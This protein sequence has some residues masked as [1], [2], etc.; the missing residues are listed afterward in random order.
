MYRVTRPKTVARERTEVLERRLA[1]L[2]GR[3][4]ERRRGIHHDRAE[5]AA[6]SWVIPFARAE[7]ERL[8][9]LAAQDHRRAE[10]GDE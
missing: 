6:L 2:R 7:V 1:F 8:A 4:R 5:A 9:G 10:E 3:V